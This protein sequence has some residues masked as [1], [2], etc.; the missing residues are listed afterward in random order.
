M[1]YVKDRNKIKQNRINNPEFTYA[2]PHTYDENMRVIKRDVGGKSCFLGIS[3]K[4]SVKIHENW[5][6]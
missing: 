2:L 3:K 5:L 1:K 4:R 6:L